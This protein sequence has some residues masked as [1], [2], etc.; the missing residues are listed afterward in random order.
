MLHIDFETKSVIDI[1]AA[2]ADVYARHPST[3]VMCMG[4]AVDG[5]TVKLWTPES[6]EF[7]PITPSTTVVAHNAPFELAIWNH[8]GVKRYGWQPLDPHQIQCTMAMAYSMGLPG[9]L[10]GA[11]AAAGL[12][13]QKDM[14]GNRIMLQLSRPRDFTPE[15]KPVWWSKSDAPEKFERL[16]AYC[17]QDIEVERELFKRLMQLSVKEREVW[18]MDY[19]INQRGVAMDLEA[20]KAA[21]AIVELEERRL[22]EEMRKVTRNA[23]ASCA[24]VAQL[25]AF[26]KDHGVFLDGVAKNDVL[27][28][29][30][31]PLPDNCRQALLLRQ[32]AAKS[33]TK[34]LK[35]MLASVCEDGRIRGI[36]QYHGAGTGRWAG[37]RI[38]PQNFPRPR[39][40]QE[41]IEGVFDV[42]NE[43]VK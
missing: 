18:L 9:S 12:A 34:K 29:L 36:F 23:V 8:V 7:P 22:N 37:R 19:K 6:G 30:E 41:E 38:Q 14:T 17:K 10:D 33:S 13:F 11:A 16:Y 31:Q 15:G 27:L 42:L 24:A 2:G 1:K 4:W 20:A 39:L 43:G 5:G 25:G 32:E 21:L 28:A 35:A 26:L 3:E 40:S